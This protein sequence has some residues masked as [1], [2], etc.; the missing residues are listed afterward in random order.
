VTAWELEHHFTLA[1][2]QQLYAMIS[3]AQPT[4]LPPPPKLKGPLSNVLVEGRETW[5]PFL[6]APSKS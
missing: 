6:V 4:P 2:L 5:R 1:E 3:S